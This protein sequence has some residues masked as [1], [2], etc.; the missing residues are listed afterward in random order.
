LY[1]DLYEY[2]LTFRM[3][4]MSCVRE[5]E[6]DRI[7]RMINHR[8]DWRQR[9]PNFGG[10]WASRRGQIT[11]EQ[12]ANCHAM[13]DFLQAKQ[14]YK[15]TVSGDWGYIYTSDLGLIRTV[16]Q[17]PYV[18]AARLKRSVLDRPRDTLRIQNSQHEF[19]SYFRAQRLDEP[20]RHNLVDF[21]IKQESI[22]LGPGL[23]QFVEQ[24]QKHYYVSENFFIDHDG[25]GIVTMLSLLL[26]RITRK[27]VKLI[28]DK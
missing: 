7:D 21:L 11:E 5:M 22:R 25:M 3:D 13:L 17:L 23:A 14:N 16:E 20:Q 2:C 15:I 12:R 27:T 6:H 26:P 10:S 19:R 8:N 1:F 4:E 18:H 9:S 28:R 24:D